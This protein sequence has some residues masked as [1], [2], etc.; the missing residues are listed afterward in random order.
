M[1]RKVLLVS[2]NGPEPSFG[3]GQR[4][5][6]IGKLFESLGFTVE[7]VLLINMEWG[8]YDENS[9]LFNEWNKRFKII[10]L[11]QPSFKRQYFPDLDITKYLKKI[12]NDYDWIIFRYEIVAFKSGFYLL[13]KNKIIVDFDDFSIPSLSSRKKYLH[14][15]RHI[16]QYTRIQKA[17]ILTLSDKNYFYKKSILIPNIPIVTHIS[18]GNNNLFVKKKSNSPTILY[19][20]NN[21]KIEKE[22]FTSKAFENLFISIQGLKFIFICKEND[23]VLKERLSSYPIIWISKPVELETYYSEA[24][25][26]L[27]LEKKYLGTHIKVIESI[28]Y[29]TPVIGFKEAFRGY[30]LFKSP[31]YF[32]SMASSVEEICEKIILLMNDKEHLES[33]SKKWKKIQSK[34]Y[35]FRPVLKSIEGYFN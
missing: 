25:L 4:N 34:Y 3:G 20:V 24:W 29:E 22:F 35:S 6:L 27:I 8:Q 14:Y 31:I 33:I 32:N 13:K 1:S 18:A 21:Y 5:I 7:M 26:L 11:F 16:I 19:Y 10:K 23:E 28:Y 17:F 15:L 2:N 9:N 12:Q 30:E